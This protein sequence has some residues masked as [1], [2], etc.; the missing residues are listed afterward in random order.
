VEN[1]FG[2]LLRRHRSTRGLSQERL[3]QDAEIS[4]RHLSCL[5]TG[6]AAPSRTMVLVLGSALDLPLRERNGL[7]QAAGFTSAYADAPLEAPEAASLRRAVDLVLGAVE[8]NGAVAMDRAWNVL[9]MNRAATSLMS[10]F[11]DLASVPPQVMRNVLVATLHPQGLRP[12][13]V[14]FE[15]VAAISLERARHEAARWPDDPEIARVR[16]VVAEIPD[17]PPPRALPASGPFITVHLRRGDV[18][19]RLFTTLATIGTPI[20]ATA[21]ELRIETYFPADE[22]TAAF[23]RR[24]ASISVHTA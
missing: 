19:A 21:E 20:D 8:P 18:E 12:W 24:L 7:L 11:L 1:A 14:N 4:T 9:A 17:L 3:A 5:E 16:A 13:I 10:T 22:A 23:V 2:A 6:R 15:E